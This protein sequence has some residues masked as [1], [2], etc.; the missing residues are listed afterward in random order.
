MV[1]LTR[2]WM[3]TLVWIFFQM[4]IGNNKPTKKLVKEKTIGFPMLLD[5]CE[6]DQISFLLVGKT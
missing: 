6:G 2:K 5:G 1:F 3:M 4:I